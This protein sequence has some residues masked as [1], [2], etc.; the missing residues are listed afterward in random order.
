[1]PDGPSSKSPSNWSNTTFPILL[2]LG[3]SDYREGGTTIDDSLVA[4]R[5]FEK[6][7]IDVL[8]IS[9]GFSGY[10]V[11]GISGQGYFAPLSEAIKNV[12]SIPVILTGGVTEPQVAERLFFL[13]EN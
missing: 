10:Q 3:A 5:E 6:A 4:A 7:G 9:G 2:R 13:K 11:P 1:M 12:V 8:D